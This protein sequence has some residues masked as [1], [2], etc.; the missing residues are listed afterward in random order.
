M[1]SSVVANYLVTTAYILRYCMQKL[2]EN[3]FL[4]TYAI[5][6]DVGRIDNIFHSLKEKFYE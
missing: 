6:T 4:R 1:I 5:S 3:Y 2:L